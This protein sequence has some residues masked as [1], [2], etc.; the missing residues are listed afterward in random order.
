MELSE[1]KIKLIALKNNF[2]KIDSLD[3][4]EICKN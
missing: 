4:V 1:S 2:P 3:H